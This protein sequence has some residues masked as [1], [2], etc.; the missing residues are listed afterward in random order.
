MRV[1]LNSTDGSLFPRYFEITNDPSNQ[2]DV[3][4]K[5]DAITKRRANSNPHSATDFRDGWIEH[6]PWKKSDHTWRNPKNQ[7]STL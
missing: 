5:H 3:S 7:P 1:C 6:L 2:R 4:Q